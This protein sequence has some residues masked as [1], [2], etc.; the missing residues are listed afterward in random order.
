VGLVLGAVLAI[1]RTSQAKSLDGKVMQLPEERI[2]LVFVFRVFAK[3][4][5]AL[6][7]QST[8]PIKVLDAVKTP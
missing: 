6:V 8:S 1:Y 2:G 5:Y 4:S 3:I 7:V